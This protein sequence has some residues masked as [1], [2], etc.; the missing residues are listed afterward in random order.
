MT[1]AAVVAAVAAAV[2]AAECLG[3]PGIL[4]RAPGPGLEG[5]GGAA[6]SGRASESGSA[7]RDTISTCRQLSDSSNPPGRGWDHI[8]IIARQ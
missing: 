5:V 7:A 8:M 6:A 2:A 1:P 4:A 3:G